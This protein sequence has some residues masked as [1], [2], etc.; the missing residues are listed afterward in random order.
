MWCTES[1]EYDELKHVSGV[2]AIRKPRQSSDLPGSTLFLRTLNLT[3]KLLIVNVLLLCNDISTN[4]G[5]AA[6]QCNSGLGSTTCGEDYC[7]PYPFFDLGLGDK[8]LRVGHWNIN[9]LSTIK[10]DQ[11]KLLW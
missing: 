9:G 6:V 1:G 8:G 7:D 2:A 3:Q 11:I 4:P 5:P 10:F